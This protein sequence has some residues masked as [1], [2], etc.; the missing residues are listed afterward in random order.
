MIGIILYIII[1]FIF[2]FILY[3][4][5]NLQLQERKK[6]FDT[7]IEYKEFWIIYILPVFWIVSM[8]LML[9]WIIMDK[10]Y[11]LINKNNN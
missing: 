5:Y 6:S 3:K 2:L 8:P 10:I 11:Q 4:K 7:P 1:G 9:L